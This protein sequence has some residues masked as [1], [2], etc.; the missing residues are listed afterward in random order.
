MCGHASSP[1]W[2]SW[3]PA[4]PTC[5]P[6]SRSSMRRSGSL[7]SARMDL[8]IPASKT[9][10]ATK[11]NNGTEIPLVLLSTP[12]SLLLKPTAQALLDYLSLLFSPFCPTPECVLFLEQKYFDSLS[13]FFFL[14]RRSRRT[15][16]DFKT[17]YNAN[18]TLPD[19]C[20]STGLSKILILISLGLS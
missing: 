3:P 16:S 12:P 13:L 5:A 15:T 1:Q 18:T 19:T 14:A 11:S 2:A 9:S 6:Y 4:C 8:E 17:I 20:L 10:W 7:I